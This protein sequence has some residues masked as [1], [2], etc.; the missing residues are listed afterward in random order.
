[1]GPSETK[2]ALAPGREIVRCGGM[3]DEGHLIR[4]GFAV[5]PVSLRVGPRI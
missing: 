1:M 4:H 3:G 5:P 2:K